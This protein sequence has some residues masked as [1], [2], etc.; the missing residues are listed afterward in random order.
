MILRLL[1]GGIYGTIALI[2]FDPAPARSR[3][4]AAS[5]LTLRPATRFTGL[6]RLG[7]LLRA[8]PAAKV[9][10]FASASGSR[11]K[12][13]NVHWAHH[14]RVYQLYARVIMNSLR[15]RTAIRIAAVSI[16]LA[17][18]GSARLARRAEHAEEATVSA[19]N[20]ETRRL[21]GRFDAVEPSSRTPKSMPPKQPTLFQVAFSTSSRSRAPRAPKKRC[22]NVRRGQ[23]HRKSA[24]ETRSSNYTSASYLSVKLEDNQWIVRIFVPLRASPDSKTGR[25]TGYFEGVRVVPD[26]Q[27][28]QM[29]SNAL[30]AALMVVLASLLCGAAIYPVVVHLSSDNERKAR[31]VLDSHISIMEA[32]AVQWQSRIR[33]PVR[34]IIASRGS[35]R[36]S[37]NDSG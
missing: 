6:F 11:L 4:P 34:T 30:S 18:R 14:R 33:I 3:R 23:D 9:G 27:R 10:R 12:W 31:E 24:P 21:L 1:T 22:N 29:I 8:A 28:Q 20:Q 37:R 32:W 26:W 17:D 36:A 25:I 2:A 35:L 19:C 15:K 5:A 7:I 13:R 16:V